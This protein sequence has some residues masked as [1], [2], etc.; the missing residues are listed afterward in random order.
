MPYCRKTAAISVG[1]WEEKWGGTI[2]EG[3]KE[4]RDLGGI[5]ICV[6]LGEQQDCSLAIL[7]RGHQYTGQ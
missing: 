7:S 4:G 5:V 1:V 2:G 6:P 3:G